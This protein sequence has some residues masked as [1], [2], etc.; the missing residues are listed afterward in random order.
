MFEHHFSG[1]LIHWHV[2][3]WCGARA[4][5]FRSGT[6]T[7]SDSPEASKVKENPIWVSTGLSLVEKRQKYKGVASD[8]LLKISRLTPEIPVVDR[9]FVS[10]LSLSPLHQS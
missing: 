5:Q 3:C 6:V 4:A 1:K 8:C 10:L 2:F 7:G 9:F